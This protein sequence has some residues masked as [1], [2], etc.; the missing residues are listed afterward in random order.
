MQWNCEGIKTKI[1][2]G[3]AL[4]FIK[5]S[6][7]KILVW[8]ETKLAK[9]QFFR[10]KGFKSYLKNLEVDGPTS[11]GGVGIFV[12]NFAS[13]YQIKLNTSLQAVA[14]SVKIQARIT[15]CSIYL[16]P[17]EPVEL[18]QLQQLI[19]QL[20]KPFLL[21]G[22]FN[23][24][25]SMWHDSRNTDQRG[26]TIVNLIGTNNISLL[27]GNKMTTIW[28]VDKS[29]AHVDLSICSNELLP[30][31]Q[32]DVHEE[33][34]NSDHFP[35]MKKSRTADQD[36]R[37]ERWITA[38]SDWE[39]YRESTKTNKKI[40]EFNSVDEAA[41]FFETHVKD[42]AFKFIPKTK[43]IIKSK[44]P[45]W[46]NKWCKAAVQKRKASFRRY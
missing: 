44:S 27:D 35:I 10:I 42:A 31:F 21:L 12:K 24:H 46:W 19:D 32:W 11:H 36:R 28:K 18:Y 3:D 14:V 2:S 25:H 17:R 5:E 39:Q 6:G 41:D 33:T 43:G 34:L 7:A 29:F 23:A 22:D 8:Q 1:N 38:K 16:P 30:W 45:P 26:R 9:D 13:S 40:E 37:P 20:P 15:I 4:Q